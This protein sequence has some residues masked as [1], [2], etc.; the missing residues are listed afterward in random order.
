[1]PVD[2]T[3]L[4]LLL[5]LLLGTLAQAGCE[6]VAD[7]PEAP[8]FQELEIGDPED[9]GE[10]EMSGGVLYS[11]EPEG[12]C[13]GNWSLGPTWGFFRFQL[14]DDLAA[15][16]V[17]DDARLS[18]WGLT[19]AGRWDA[20]AHGLTLLLEDSDDATRVE[21]PNDHPDGSR[22]AVG[23][24]VDWPAAGGLAWETNDWN[25]SPDLSSMFQELVDG[26]D[27]LTGGHSL[28]LWVKARDDVQGNA[29]VVCEDSSAVEANPARLVIAWH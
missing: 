3:T 8:R 22:T 13:I 20:G 9:D 29:E 14:A 10:I 2:S 24:T 12:L 28:L 23:P 4:H 25:I 21:D 5:A 19:T 18:L 15:D 7:F 1:M 6:Y 27:G 11:G 17:V 26:R 16:A